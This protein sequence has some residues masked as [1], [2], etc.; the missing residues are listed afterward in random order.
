MTP[1]TGGAEKGPNDGFGKKTG[2]WSG[3]EGAGLNAAAWGR[4]KLDEATRG[5]W[6]GAW[7]P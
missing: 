3:G 7:A 4:Q 1:A 5:G 6:G 2:D